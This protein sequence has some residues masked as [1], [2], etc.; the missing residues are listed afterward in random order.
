MCGFFC[1]PLNETQGLHVR[2]SGR[3]VR[4]RCLDEGLDQTELNRAVGQL[5]L[6]LLFGFLL[7]ACPLLLLLH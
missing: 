1:E 2:N 4:S 3:M 6:W 5:H 7:A